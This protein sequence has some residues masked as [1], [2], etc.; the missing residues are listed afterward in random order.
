MGKAQRDK[1]NRS[2]RDFARRIG[3]HRIPLSGSM[4]GYKGDVQGLGLVWEC[5]VRKDGFKQIYQ[6]LEH[7]AK[8]ALA[9]KADR[10]DWLVV[11][12]LEKFLEI[13]KGRG[14]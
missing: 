5:K 11:M 10:K 9:I 4:A 2:E 1:G 6:W 12:P 8:D 3:G 13:T 14:E 7:E